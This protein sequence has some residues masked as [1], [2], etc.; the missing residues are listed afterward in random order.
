[1]ISVC[2]VSRPRLRADRWLASAATRIPISRQAVVADSRIT[3]A[4]AV[5]GS[6]AERRKRGCHRQP[7]RLIA[8]AA[9]YPRLVQPGGCDGAQNN[10]AVARIAGCPGARD[11][12]GQRH[13]DQVA[14]GK[15]PDPAARAPAAR[16]VRHAG[17]LAPGRRGWPSGHPRAAGR[18]LAGRRGESR[19]RHWPAI[20]ASGRA[21]VATLE[22]AVAARCRVTVR[23]ACAL[24]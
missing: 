18:A 4:P 7:A 13:R 22:S 21:G 1:M 10:K 3:V 5:Q 15:H 24:P 2:C 6:N 14:S 20:P 8:G 11:D 19:D 23:A 17:S 9:A 12:C 16:R